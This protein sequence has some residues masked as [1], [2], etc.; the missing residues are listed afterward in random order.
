MLCVLWSLLFQV[1]SL[2]NE[3]WCI[4]MILM[5]FI[6]CMCYKYWAILSVLYVIN[7]L[8][9]ALRFLAENRKNIHKSLLVIINQDWELDLLQCHLY[10]GG[11]WSL[12]LVI[13]FATLKLM[14]NGK[15]CQISK[16]KQKKSKTKN[17]TKPKQRRNL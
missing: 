11:D 15:Y 1:V 6:M 3:Y 12:K 14:W 9:P 4:M 10:F 17:K 8:L 2:H 7:Q 13:Q 5:I 16:T